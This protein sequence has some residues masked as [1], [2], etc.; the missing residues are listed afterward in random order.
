MFA[1]NGNVSAEEVSANFHRF[2]ELTETGI[3]TNVS[4]AG[5]WK[6]CLILWKD[7]AGSQNE[8]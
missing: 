5:A 2:K 4:H 7:L 3:V 8:L 1:L 6:V